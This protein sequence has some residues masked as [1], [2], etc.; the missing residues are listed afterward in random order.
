MN[1]ILTGFMGTGKTSVGK[2]LAKRLG[3]TFV[4]VDELIEA[5][6][7]MS[8]P[9]IFAERGEAV[10][11]RLE[12]RC[13]GRVIKQRNQVIA[14]GGGAFVDPQSRARLRV[15]GPVMC[16]TARP[17]VILAR[18]GR[19]LISRPMLAGG[20]NSLARIRALLAQRAKAYAQADLT[21]DT[22]DLSIEEVVERISEQLRSCLSQSWQYLCDHTA[23]LSARYAGKYIVVANQRI[24]GSGET[25]LKAYQHAAQRL[26]E[27]AETGIY[28]IPLPEESV[29]ALCTTVHS[30]WSI[31]HSHNPGHVDRAFTMDYGPWTMDAL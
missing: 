4:D 16:L 8:I 26:S 30:P 1:I 6:A 27:R 23:K 12:R 19:K 2:R 31:V 25:Q 24:V 21:I 15:S 14:T 3:W 13:I 9:R 17:A 11:R 5:R 29:T 22:S 7:R 10:F 18:L 28:Y 20:T